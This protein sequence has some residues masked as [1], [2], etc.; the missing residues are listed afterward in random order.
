[1]KENDMKEN[2]T[3]GNDMKRKQVVLYNM[4]LPIW[5]LVLFPLC[6]L[7]VIP[8]NFAIDSLVLWFGMRKHQLTA[9][10]EM[11][12]KC[13][14]KIVGYGFLSDFIGGLFMLSPLF[15]EGFFPE[16]IG[17][18]VTQNLG[19]AVMYNPL[20]NPFSLLWTL[21][22]MAIASFCIYY[23]N[24]KSTFA[25]LELDPAVQKESSPAFGNF[26]H[27]SVVFIAN[28]VVLLT[29]Y[30]KIRIKIQKGAVTQ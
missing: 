29:Q 27:T 20:K 4:I 9:H 28:R 13:I 10:K 7:V 2:G 24:S 30:R 3:Q 18:W 5:L 22:A 19:N 17:M 15:L 14:L 8:L 6:W 21:T 23:F 11:Y 1:M 12:K 26:N 16:K 25:D